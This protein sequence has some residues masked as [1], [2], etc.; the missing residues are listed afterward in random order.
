[1]YVSAV[2][3]KCIYSFHYTLHIAPEFVV[4]PSAAAVQLKRI[5]SLKMVNVSK[6]NEQLRT[7]GYALTITM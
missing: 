2:I 6:D 4:A 5:Y 3:R 7:N 1:M